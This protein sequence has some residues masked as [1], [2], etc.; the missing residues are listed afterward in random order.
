MLE[1]DGVYLQ[2][3][4]AAADDDVVIHDGN[5]HDNIDADNV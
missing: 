1:D 3:R 2:R 4:D 5:V